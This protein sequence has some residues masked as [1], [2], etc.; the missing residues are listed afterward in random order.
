MF[1]EHPT[2]SS[3]AECICQSHC[4]L[5][6]CEP[7][8]LQH[9]TNL[10]N[11]FE[12]QLDEY[13]RSLTSL[14]EQVRSKYKQTKER[15]QSELNSIHNLFNRSS[16][17]LDQH[18]QF[19]KL[20]QEIL[21]TKRQ[22]LIQYRNGDKQLTKINY[23]EIEHLSNDMQIH[24]EGQYKLN[25]EILNKNY[26]NISYTTNHSPNDIDCIQLSDSEYNV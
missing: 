4:H 16:Y 13:S 8:R 22:D 23:E 5:S 9:E 7:H 11:E 15:Q 12:K 24:L 6:V 2:C 20:T 25:K 19:S 10:L 14:L 18:F 21:K 1:C 26:S 17:V 3:I